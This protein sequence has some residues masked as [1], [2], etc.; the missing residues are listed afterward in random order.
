MQC[1]ALLKPYSRQ[2]RD[3]GRVEEAFEQQ[4]RLGPAQFAQAHRVL[5]LDQRQAV[6]VGEAAHAALEA[7]AVGV[8]LDHPQILAAG[9]QARARARLCRMESRWMVALSGLGIVKV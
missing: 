7:V 1:T 5:G 3:V 8:G 2:Q 9:A 6:G 4:D